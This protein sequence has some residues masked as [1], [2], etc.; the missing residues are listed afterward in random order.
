MVE[1]AV[2]LQDG[3]MIAYID[4]VEIVA[5]INGLDVYILDVCIAS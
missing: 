3:G 1:S 2:V 4:T 5:E